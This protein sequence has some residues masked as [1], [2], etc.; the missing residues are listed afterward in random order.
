LNSFHKVRH[1]AGPVFFLML[2]CLFLLWGIPSAVADD[3]SSN[4]WHK[5][6]KFHKDSGRVRESP[7]KERAREASEGNEATG[8]TAAWLFLA[9]NLKILMNFLIK[10]VV[11]FLP[12]RSEMRTGLEAFNR[13]QNKFL[14][15]WHFYLNLLAWGAALLHFFLS[16]CPSPRLPE[17]GLLGATLMVFMGLLLKIKG[18]PKRVR[19]IVYA[20]HTHPLVFSSLAAL[21]LAGH[22]MM[23]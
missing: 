22:L 5:E 21:V 14:R 9:A 1:L 12:A 8:Q 4:G 13:R 10:G 3:H 15:P 2:T 11:R 19:K 23:D 20:C 7:D 16:T 17:W 18:T 6:K